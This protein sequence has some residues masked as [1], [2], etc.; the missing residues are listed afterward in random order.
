MTTPP[1]ILAVDDQASF[2]F[3]L[4]Q[5][6][7]NAG[8][9]PLLASTVKEALALMERQPVDLV[10]S[11]LVMPDV[12]GLAF[13]TRM[14]ERYSSIPFILLTAHGTVATAVEALKL[15]A[16]D[17]VEKHC[18][19][20]ELKI[21]LQRA[22]NYRLLADENRHFRQ[23]QQERFNFQAINT[24]SPAM[25]QALELAASVVKSPLTTLALFGASGCGK[26][27]LARSIHVAGGGLPNTFVG[28][29]C[30]A[31]PETLLES[32]LFGH[33]RGAFTGAD[34]DREGKFSMAEGG[35]LLLDEIGDMPLALQAKL[36]RVLE[37][38]QF[39][40]IGSDRASTLKCRVI[41]A[42]HR[43]LA[44][45]VAEGKF[46][47]DLYHR[48]N[49]FPI[50]I[51]PLC[52]RTE[53]IPILVDHFIS[54]FRKHL[55]KALPGVSQQTME[56]LLAYSWPGNVRELRNCLE[57]A[58]ILIQDGELMRVEHFDLG[59]PK[60]TPGDVTPAH[61]IGYRLSFPPEELS[62]DAA[63]NRILDITLER[64]DGNK[65]K[66]AALLKV[67]RKMFYR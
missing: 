38:R 42:T 44:F 27:V 32:E 39:E 50:A 37:E 62:L 51:P 58:A 25:K 43:N 30:A 24:T 10:L 1:T 48:I 7:S 53:D 12:D 52:E 2:R 41:V 21:T 34:R 36:L 19:P 17:Y 28:V 54:L 23:H 31:I 61:E 29:N 22:L 3:L 33:V 47:E 59:P 15:G 6:L 5:Q 55:G 57:R 65:T 20:E 35:T 64:C 60:A 66:A 46:R 14:Q 9:N 67:N 56:A 13:L 11:D 18:P 40:K 8:F 45:L 49:I 26:E 4:Q 16:F 63:T